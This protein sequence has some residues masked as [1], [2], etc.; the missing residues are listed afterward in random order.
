MARTI[1]FA[2]GTIWRWE[3]ER[4]KLLKYARK[5]DVMGIE[6]TLDTTETLYNFKLPAADI[7]WLKNLE[8]VTIHAP[9]G[10]AKVSENEIELMRQLDTLWKLYKDVNAK[11]LIIHPNELPPPSILNKYRFSVSTENMERM[12]R[13]S[14]HDLKKTLTKYPDIGLCL[15]ASHAY[16]FNKYE[17]EKL[18][19]NF[20]NRITQI[21]FSGTYRNK[22]HQ[23][24]RM[25][26]NEFLQSIAPLKKLKVPL[27]IEGDIRTKDIKY[28]KDEIDLIKNLFM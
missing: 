9:F 23:D 16:T 22:T 14:V 28:V 11:N 19:D 12:R 15:D 7:K 8:Y 27:I 24:M 18:I 5:L 2:I 10:L 6:L 4:A 26:T 25:V 1:S 3:K 17:I 13:F 20:K 21:H